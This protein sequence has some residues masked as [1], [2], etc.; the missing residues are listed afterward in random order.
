VARKTAGAKKNLIV[1]LFL[2]KQLVEEARRLGVKIATIARQ[3]LETF[4]EHPE[5]PPLKLRVKER[6]RVDISVPRELG[7]ELKKR[8]GPSTATWFVSRRL[9]AAIEMAKRVLSMPTE[10]FMTEFFADKEPEETEEALSCSEPENMSPVAHDRDQ[11]GMLK[12]VM[13][14]LALAEKS[15]D[16]A[17]YRGEAMLKTAESLYAVAR[18]LLRLVQAGWP[19]GAVRSEVEEVVES[20]PSR[21][22]LGG[23]V[24][25]G[26]GRAGPA[27]PEEDEDIRS[28]SRIYDSQPRTFSLRERERI[29]RRARE[30]LEAVEEEPVLPPI[31]RAAVVDGD[32]LGEPGPEPER[33]FVSTPENLAR[34]LM[35]AGPEKE[36]VEVP[37]VEGLPSFFQDNPWVSILANRARE[38]ELVDEHGDKGR[39]FFP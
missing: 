4:V 6:E 7:E 21:E 5:L 24:V 9:Q 12:L 28:L 31:E 36:R 32:V 38:A 27:G 23:E 16:R 8:G 1:T 2:P 14:V 18:C 17:G 34:Y 3:A 19:G 11:A 37:D 20:V 25:R 33:A 22:V 10:E 26:Q 39:R 30:T 13:R 35:E 29:V 15:M